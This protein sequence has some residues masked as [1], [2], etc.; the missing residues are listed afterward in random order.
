VAV[1]ADRVVAAS[2]GVLD[3]SRIVRHL[4]GFGQVY[5]TGHAPDEIVQHIEL[6]ERPLGPGGVLTTVTSGNPAR[7]LVMATDRPRLLL[8]VAGV[9]ALARLSIVDARL[10]TRSDG[11]VFDTF[12]L[13]TADG[14]PLSPDQAG[15]LA[16]KIDQAI[17][18]GMAHETEVAAKQQA[19]RSM[20]PRGVHPHVAIR[21]LPS[22]DGIVEFECADR[23]G[24]L[25]DVAT[26]LDR[27]GMPIS[28]ARVD[29]RGGVAYSNLHVRRVPIP[30][31]P[32]IDQLLAAIGGENSSSS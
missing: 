4:T 16:G 12:D 7:A 14:T 3:R 24:L 13:V 10:A 28:R 21:H 29:T 26:V 20:P 22:G 19:Y 6:A 11:F 31:Q 5:R 15:E 25:L 18:L 1:L 17:R 30:D 32:L 9:V 2:E 23:V 27:W 8:A